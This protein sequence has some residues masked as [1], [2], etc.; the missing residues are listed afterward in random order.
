MT[1]RKERFG[2]AL[3]ISLEGRLDAKSSPL[4]ESELEQSYS[5]LH[6]LN[7]DIRGLE[8]ISSA[9]LRVLLEAQRRMNRQGMMSLSGARQ[10][11]MDALDATGF[12]QI[13]MIC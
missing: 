10:Q 9:G 11:V 5:G 8:Y 7:I 2:D 4:L 13:M 1:I 6:E 3:D 12:S